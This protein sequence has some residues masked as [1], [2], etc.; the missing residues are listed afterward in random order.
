MQQVT[1]HIPILVMDKQ[2]AM[3]M[4]PTTLQKVE[5][6]FNKLK[7]K[8]P[9]PDGLTINFFCFLLGPAQTGDLQNGI[10]IT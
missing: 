6:T 2:N 5:T 1:S 7:D 8:A 4:K 10:R 3:L 9:R